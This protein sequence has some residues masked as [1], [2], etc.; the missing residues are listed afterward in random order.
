MAP[1]IGPLIGLGSSLIGGAMGKGAQKRQEQLTR[2]QMAQV[3]PL[4]DAQVQ[5]SNF[6]LG[7]AMQFMPRAAVMLDQDRANAEGAMG[8]AYGDR[9]TALM[10]YRK[11]LDDAL[12]Q[13]D[14][15]YSE[16]QATRA[17]GQNLLSGSSQYLKGAGAALGDLQRFYRPFMNEGQRAIDRFLPSAQRTMEAFAPEFGNVNQAAQSASEN[18]AKFA[19]RGGSVSSSNSVEIARQKGISD[20]FFQGRQ[21][22]Q[23]KGLQNA[24]QGAQGQQQ[25]AQLLQ[26]LGLGQG[27]LGLN[28]IGQGLNTTNT[29]TQAFATGGGLAQNA[30]SQGQNSLSQALAAIG[31]SLQANQGLADIGKFGLSASQGGGN[32]F[33]LYNQQANRS[34]AG[35]G[36]N[37]AEGLGASLQRLFSNKSV[38]DKIGGWLGGIFSGNKNNTIPGTDFDIGM[39][40]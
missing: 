6:G 30:F 34:A 35:S 1:A 31:Q 38:Q 32:V 15:L 3:Q 10:D 28:A 27:G 23:D 11:L 19:P 39:G 5:A 21:S 36:T 33:D 7:Q 25:V 2:Q 22:L 9:A 20:T 14:R 24:F 26:S 16:G 12:T 13:R 18:I 17:T 4:I 37:A 40:W 29:G 8:Q